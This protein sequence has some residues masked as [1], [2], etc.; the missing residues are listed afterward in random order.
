MISAY[1]TTRLRK[2]VI[3][4]WAIAGIGLVWLGWKVAFPPPPDNT[5]LVFDEPGTTQ[6]VERPNGHAYQYIRS[7]N[8]TWDAAK[9]A[10]EKLT[11]KGQRGYLATMNDRAEMDFVMKALFPDPTDVVYIGG[12]Q[13]APNEWRW[14]TGPDASED[15]GKGRLF[16]T[17][18]A[19]GQAPEGAFADWMFTAFQHG[20]TGQSLETIKIGLPGCIGFF[21]PIAPQRLHCGLERIVTGQTLWL[22]AGADCIGHK[23]LDAG[24]RPGVA[25][26]QI[27]TFG[28]QF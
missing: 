20:S 3:V 19:R 28:A 9:A 14:V 22:D 17:G 5:P 10:A 8:L 21:H 11:H 23:S 1:A 27:T 25:A 24:L 26:H 2:L 13:T 16:W 4:L 7:P 12:R 6:V 18:N 15:G